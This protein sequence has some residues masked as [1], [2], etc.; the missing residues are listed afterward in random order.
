MP[1]AMTEAFLVEETPTGAPVAPPKV[2]PARAPA[3]QHESETPNERA[4]RKATAARRTS[5]T[6]TRQQG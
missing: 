1:H 4:M 3:R 5:E 2:S 6:R